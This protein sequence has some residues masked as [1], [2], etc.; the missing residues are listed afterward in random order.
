MFFIESNSTDPYYQLALEEYIFTHLDPSGE[1]CMLWR[2]R[3]TIYVARRQNT[4]SVIDQDFVEEAG[5]RV[6]RRLSGGEA[7]YLD[8]DNLAFTYISGSEKDPEEIRA[9]FAEAI[10]KALAELGI[11]ADY[12]NDI[13]TIDGKRFSDSSR[14]LSHGRLIC[15]GYIRLDSDPEKIRTALR[16][17]R[18]PVSSDKSYAA[19]VTSVNAQLAQP[20]TFQHFKTLLKHYLAEDD[21]RTYTLTAADREAVN[22]LLEEKYET[23]EWN[24]GIA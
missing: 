18:G 20:V 4:A 23:W 17:N 9:Y 8:D 13:L 1:Y 16:K 6:A 3:N 12:S 24:Y 22:T 10:R 7:V 21:S 2:S 5:I 15:H 19:P 14:F 11:T